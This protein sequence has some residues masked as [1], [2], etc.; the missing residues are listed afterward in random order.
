VLAAAMPRP[1][2]CTE[3]LQTGL[4]AKEK[5]NRGLRLRWGERNS[6]CLRFGSVSFCSAA[7]DK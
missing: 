2:G 7:L 5:Q 1:M 4:F 3:T 6:L